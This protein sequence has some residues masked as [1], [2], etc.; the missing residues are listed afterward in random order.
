MS[1]KLSEIW[2][3]IV[4]VNLSLLLACG[5]SSTSSRGKAGDAGTDASGSTA[6]GALGSGG[7]QGGGGKA[8]ATGTGAASMGAASMG[9]TSMGGK[10][11]AG[12]SASSAQACMTNNDCLGIS[13][14]CKPCEDGGFSCLSLCENGKCVTTPSTCPAKCGPTLGC[15]LYDAPSIDCGGDVSYAYSTCH[16]GVCEATIPECGLPKSCRG[17]ACGT[18]C[19]LCGPD[20]VCDESGLAACS[21]DGVCTTEQLFCGATACESKSDCG[22]PPPDCTPCS[23]GSCATFDCLGKRCALACPPN[24]ALVCKLAADCPA[25]PGECESCPNGKCALP[26]CLDNTC[27]LVCPVE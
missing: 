2:G 5:G 20:G 7:S 9:A 25:I 19:A 21:E 15:V 18:P 13:D 12:G 17:Q 26:T 14:E 10:A 11:S 4:S 16:H 8:G 23:D 3:W 6:G 1:M 27:Q 24:A 22:E